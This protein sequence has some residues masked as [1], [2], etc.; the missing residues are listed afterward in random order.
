MLIKILIL[1]FF[2]DNSLALSSLIVVCLKRSGEA[3]NIFFFP[4]I[5]LSSLFN[6]PIRPQTTLS[7]TIWQGNF[8]GCYS[9]MSPYG[10]NQ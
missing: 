7:V 4:R 1:Q 3:K 5:Y 6:H 10:N 8:G 2:S 9:M